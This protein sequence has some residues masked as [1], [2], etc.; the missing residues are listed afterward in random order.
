VLAGLIIVAAVLYLRGY[1]EPKEIEEEIAVSAPPEEEVETITKSLIVKPSHPG[2]IKYKLPEPSQQMPRVVSPSNYA[3]SKKAVDSFN[4]ENYEN[5]AILFAELSKH[6]GRALVGLG[7]SYYKLGDYRSAARFFE[8]AI[9]EKGVD[10]FQVRK[11][12]AFTYYEMDD[13]KE[14]LNNA[15]AALSIRKDDNLDALVSRLNREKPE[16]EDFIYEETLHF[17][18]IFD[19]REHGSMSRQVL[20]TLEGAYDNIGIE[21]GHFPQKSLTVILYSE[22]DFYDITQMPE[23]SGGLFDGKIRLPLRGVDEY[24]SELLKRALYHEYAHALV[25]SITPR[26]PVWVN[27]GLAMYL[28]GEVRQ[29]VGQEIPLKSLERSFPRS[30]GKGKLAY[31]VSYSAVSHLA[32]NYGLY[33]FRVFLNALAEG[34][35]VKGAFKSAFLISYD[36]FTE[37]WG[38]G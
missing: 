16:Q 9:D 26:C 12:L 31:D 32:E 30:S 29:S 24:D 6:D 25:F 5:A 28:S 23:W 35:D 3:L 36:D 13:L 19:G 17:K 21:M 11:F 15:R 34:Q 18:V 33:S 8:E 14:S 38:K 22:Q 4:S 20:D 7:L 2:D 10:E 37:S 1:W 27:E